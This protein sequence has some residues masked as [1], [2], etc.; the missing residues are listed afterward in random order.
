MPSGNPR[1]RSRGE[2]RAAPA[3]HRAEETS[4]APVIGPRG[5]GDRPLQFTRLN[6][7]LLGSA[8][9]VLVAGYVA[10]SSDSPALSTIVGPVLLVGAYAV[11]IP[12]GLIL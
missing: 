7:L 2:P 11:L 4:A 8:G 9:V 1:K 6:W 5:D 12:L 10:L 3:A